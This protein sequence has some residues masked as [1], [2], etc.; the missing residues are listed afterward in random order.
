MKNHNDMR[1]KNTS[2]GYKQKVEA[3][4]KQISIQSPCSNIFYNTNNTYDKR[5]GLTDS[6]VDNV[7]VRQNSRIADGS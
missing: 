6:G 5:S 7:I 4:R 3:K 2:Y 1:P